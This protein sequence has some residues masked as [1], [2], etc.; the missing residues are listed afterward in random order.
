MIS[1][2]SYTKKWRE[3]G[4]TS[5]MKELIFMG[6]DRDNVRET[7]LVQLARVLS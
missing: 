5:W 3:D 1:E 2:L 4:R 6:Q 7:Q